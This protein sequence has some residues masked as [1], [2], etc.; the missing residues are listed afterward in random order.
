MEKYIDSLYKEDKELLRVIQQI[1]KENMPQISIASGYG[2]LLTLLVK[3]SKAKR[4][5][6]IGA[7]GGYSGICLAR[8]LESEGTLLSL[9][10]KSEF[11][12]VAKKNLEAAGLSDKVH[13][14]I[15]DAKET[16]QQ[17]KEE[18]EQFD[19]FF[20]DADKSGYPYYLE[21][22]IQI[23]TPGAIIV[24]D[25]TLMHGKISDSQQQ[26]TSVRAMR[27][28]N[29]MIAEDPR[30]DSTILPAYDGLAIARVI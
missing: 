22:A 1:E 16:L 14:R 7:L 24:G 18:G 23:S 3:M 29:Q 13:Y 11:A 2:R 19:F 9:E 5:L 6:E 20:I 25:N 17:L 27:E 8:G 21:A 30:L 4:I 15:G 12:D 26:S 28:F 10:L